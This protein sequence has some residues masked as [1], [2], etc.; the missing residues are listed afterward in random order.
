VALSEV[1]IG[2]EVTALTDNLIVR[3]DEE[4]EVNHLEPR[5]DF[6]FSVKPA[7]TKLAIGER[8]QITITPKEQ[9]IA[10]LTRIFLPGNLALLK[11]GANAQTAYLPI[12]RK[13]VTVDVVAVRPGRGKLYVSVHDMYDAEKVGT[14]PGIELEVE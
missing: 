5:A 8:S 7:K 6:Q 4:I 1:N 11:G 3:V 12:E 10:P 9:T 13:E 2:Q 14:I